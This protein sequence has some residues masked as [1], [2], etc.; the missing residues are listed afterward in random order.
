MASADVSLLLQSNDSL[1]LEA[2]YVGE[3]EPGSKDSPPAAADVQF[4]TMPISSGKDATGLDSESGVD[5]DDLAPTREWSTG[6]CSCIP[7]STSDEH[8]SSDCEICCLGCFAP[9]VLYGSNMVRLS[10]NQ[11]EFW[12]NC[13]CYA[14]L[15]VVGKLILRLNVLAPIKSWSSRSAIRMQFGLQSGAESVTSDPSDGCHRCCDCFLHFICHRCALCQEAREIRRRV[16]PLSGP[17]SSVGTVVAPPSMQAM[18][19]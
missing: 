2:Y 17:G 15:F 6:L 5:Y 7:R 10:G 14:S 4:D 9:C 18:E 12:N 11:D 13:M 1:P 19:H 3:K 8:A 16:P